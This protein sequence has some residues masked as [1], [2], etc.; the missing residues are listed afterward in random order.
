[1]RPVLIA[2]ASTM[3][4]TQEIASAIGDRLAS[5]GFQVEVVT[6]ATWPALGASM[7][8]SSAAP[9]TSA[10]GTNTRIAYLKRQATDLALPAPTWLFQSGRGGPPPPPRAVRRLCRTIGLAEPTTF[11]GNLDPDGAESRKLKTRR[12]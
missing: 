7:P 2:Y 5:R 8:S 6:P 12:V 4:S 3:G 1:M 9:P 11:S 10:N